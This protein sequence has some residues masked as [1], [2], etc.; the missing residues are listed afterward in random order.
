MCDVMAIW[1]QPL[2]DSEWSRRAFLVYSIKGCLGLTLVGR[3]FDLQILKGD[4]Y[5]LLSDNNRIQ[6]WCEPPIRGRFLDTKGN[7]LADNEVIH[8]CYLAPEGDMQQVLMLQEALSLSPERMGELNKRLSCKRRMHPLLIKN[9]LTWQELV[10][11]EMHMVELPSILI[12]PSFWRHYPYGQSL[13]H[14][15]GYVG[16][17]S[18]AERKQM[19]EELPAIASRGG[20]QIHIGKI[21]LE[22]LDQNALIGTHGLQYAEVDAYGRKVRTLHHVPS[23]SGKDVRLTLDLNMQQAAWNVFQEAGV[24]AGSAVIVD[25]TTGAIRACVSAPSFD[26]HLF[27]KGVPHEEWAKLRESKALINK[28]IHGAYAPGSTFKMVVLLAALHSGVVDEY[29]HFHCPGHMEVGNHTFYCHAWRRGGH[30]SVNASN[31]L[32]YS[33][34]VFFYQVAL[35]LSFDVLAKVARDFGFGEHTGLEFSDE[36]TGL[37]PTPSWRKARRQPWTTGDA[38]NLVIG[39]GAIL[40][41][42]VQLARMMALL[43]NGLDAVSLHLHERDTPHVPLH[44]TGYEKDHIAIVKQGM[45]DVVQ[46]PWG[47]G[48]RACI[49]G[50]LGKTGSTQVC[51]ITQE[52]RDDPEFWAN[53]PKH[54][55][56]HAFFVGYKVPYAIAVL[57]EHGG[58]G[59]KVAAPIAAKIM[60]KI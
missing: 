11:L 32:P 60:S 40:A 57:V 5:R 10:Y 36:R 51:R 37:V 43:C 29:T 26:P 55:L 49:P 21:G 56:E 15:L 6:T 16:W 48:H 19:A 30:G 23:G 20:T 34:D 4:Y 28:A 1:T 31:A 33:C 38:L 3:L 44:I 59:G 14:T 7:I 41:T 18:K 46:K 27:L 42:P 54:L 25:A 35:R 22:K 45:E 2:E 12:T 47:T 50:M 53:R 24:E 13:A 8:S 9:C 58:S 52:Q 17:P 39:Q